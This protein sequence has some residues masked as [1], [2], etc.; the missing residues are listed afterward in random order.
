MHLHLL[1]AVELLKYRLLLAAA[2]LLLLLHTVA[3]ARP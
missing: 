3:A 2:G 1:M